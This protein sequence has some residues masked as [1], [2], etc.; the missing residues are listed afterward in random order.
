MRK[1]LVTQENAYYISFKNFSFAQIAFLIVLN[2][3]N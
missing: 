1:S 3:V 2:G